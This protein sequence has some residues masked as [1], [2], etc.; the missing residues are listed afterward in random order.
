MVQSNR[1][2]PAWPG[3]AGGLLAATAIAL[4][5]YAAHGVADAHARANLETAC[6]YAFGHGI[7][8]ACLRGQ[9]RGLLSR[10]ALGAILLGSLLFA[11]SLAGNALAGWPTRLAPAGGSLMILGWLGWAVAA[12]RR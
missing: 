6:L 3:V 2:L 9:L 5:A 1:N 8:L 4:A 11:G 7:A 10:L 12:L